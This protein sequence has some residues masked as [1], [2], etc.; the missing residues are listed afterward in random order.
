[1]LIITVTVLEL[2]LFSFC[3][4]YEASFYFIFKVES[5]LAVCVV[6]SCSRGILFF[7]RNI[8]CRI[9]K[10]LWAK[11]ILLFPRISPLRI[12]QGIFLSRTLQYV[13]SHSE[14][15]EIR[16]ATAVSL[17]LYSHFEACLGLPQCMPVI[18]FV[19]RAMLFQVSKALQKQSCFIQHNW[20]EVGL[21]I[22]NSSPALKLCLC[23]CGGRGGFQSAD[24]PL[25]CSS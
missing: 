14:E 24:M 21:C 6:S 10:F 4:E 17:R 22:C 7:F 20:F 25:V 16:M 11:P 1:M 13:A 23:V 8:G 18:L 3:Q 5:S 15:V 19:L 9:S 12:Q 2:L